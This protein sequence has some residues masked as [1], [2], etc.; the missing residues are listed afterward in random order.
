[1]LPVGAPIATDRGLLPFVAAHADLVDV[2]FV[3]SAEDVLEV[4]R[5]GLMITRGDLTVEVG[6]ERRAGLQGE[7]RWLCGAAH[8]PVVWASQVLDQLARTGGPSRP[9]I[10]DAATGVRVECVMLHEGPRVLSAVT[11]RADVLVRMARQQH[12]EVPLPG[13]LRSWP[14]PV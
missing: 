2:S 9:E 12:E 4:A 14:H 13:R 8:L 1:M 5:V 7:I 6:F 11:T 3:H 10:T